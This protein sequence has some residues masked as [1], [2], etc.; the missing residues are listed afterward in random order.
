MYRYRLFQAFFWVFAL[1]L[2]GWILPRLPLTTILTSLSRLSPVQW[3]LWAALNVG[4]L[5]VYVQRWRCLLTAAGL[6][7]NFSSVFLLRQAGQLVSFITPGPQFG[8][9]PFQVYWLWK[10]FSASGVVALL[11]VVLDRFYELWVNFAFLLLGLAVLMLTPALGLADWP[12]LALGVTLVILGLSCSGWFLVSHQEQLSVWIKKLGQRWRHSARLSRIE[13]HWDEL[14]V[15]LRTLMHAE[16]R[17]L[18]FALLLSL[19]GWVGMIFE[20]WLLLYFFEINAGFTTLV[21][22]LVGM[23]L[24]FLL[25]L[26]GGVGTLEAAVF[27]VFAAMGLPMPGAVAVLAM[28]RFRDALILCVGFFALYRLRHTRSLEDT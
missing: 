14:G 19:L 24:A 23:R 17:L 27:W 15:R 1:A 25:P 8:G 20:I 4:I 10:K 18:V 9:E 7:I 11:A 22:L 12:A 5:F 13:G 28:L 6:K 16:K 26:P 2:V 3:L 21:L